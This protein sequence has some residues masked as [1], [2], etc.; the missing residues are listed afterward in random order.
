M[1][2]CSLQAL[3][4]ALTGCS[5]STTQNVELI[6]FGKVGLTGCT[7]SRPKPLLVLAYIA[8]EGPQKRRKLASLFWRSDNDGPS[9][10]KKLAKLSV[11]LAQIKKEGAGA[12]FPDI[13]G[14][15]P[16]GTVLR[17]DATDFLARLEAGDRERALACY[18]GPFLQSIDSG[19]KKLQLSGELED[20]LLV[21]RETLAQRVQEALL[22]LAEEALRHGQTPNAHTLAE[23]AYTLAAAPDPEPRLLSRL[24]EVLLRTEEDSHKW[25]SQLEGATLETLPLHVRHVFL[26]LSLQES[27]NPSVVRT[28]LKLS[29]GDLSEALEELVEAGL[30]TSQGQPL[31]PKLARHWLDAHPHDALSLTLSLARA[32]PGEDAFR[33]YQRFYRQTKGVG[34]M[35]DLPRARTAYCQRA[36]ELNDAFDYNASVA[37]LMELHDAE[38]TLGAEPSPESRFL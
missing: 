19:M 6:T 28:A 22:E 3:N 27:P 32:T 36:R 1:H 17:C 7:F 25:T 8:L 33:H 12:A 24:Q 29:P 4:R 38:Q 5:R 16:L 21:T 13:P 35:G 18:Q 26:S 14:L 15:D 10:Q 11:V 37:I 30:T 34:G 20:W 23:R 9:L 31:A 2:L